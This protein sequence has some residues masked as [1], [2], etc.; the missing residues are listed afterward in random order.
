M[1][2]FRM[3]CDEFFITPIAPKFFHDYN[4]KQNKKG[5]WVSL[6]S[7]LGRVVINPFTFSYKDFKDHF[8]QVCPGVKSKS[9]CFT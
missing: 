7:N 5:G 1:C 3:L 9:I 6:I 2:A 4:V 8:F